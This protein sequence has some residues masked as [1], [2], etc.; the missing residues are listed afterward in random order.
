MNVLITGINGFAGSY[1]KNELL[2]YGFNVINSENLNILDIESLRYYV[3]NYSPNYYVH[4]AAISNITHSDIDLIY[5]TNIV[6]TRNL[7]QVIDEFSHDVKSIVLTSTGYVYGNCAPDLVDERVTPMPNNDYSISKLAMEFVSSQWNGRLPITIVR[8]FNFT[9][10]CQSTKFVFP[11][12]ISHFKNQNKLI[13]LGNIHSKREYM[14]IRSVVVAYRKI[15]ESNRFGGVYNISCGK[16]Y[17]VCEI[18]DLISLKTNF[19]LEIEINKKLIRNND[20][21]ILSGSTEK[22]TKLIGEWNT[23]AISDTIEW[24]LG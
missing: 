5:K 13:E 19:Q 14:D 11:K 6:G 24:M 7:L 1:L 23:H 9:G 4:L 8:P 12:I 17:S 21:K 15:L 3:R 2:N 10:R 20:T 18:I 22:L 16:S